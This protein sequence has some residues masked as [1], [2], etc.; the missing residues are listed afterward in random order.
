M[1][2]ILLMALALISLS[3]LPLPA[4]ADPQPAQEYAQNLRSE[5]ADSEFAADLVRACSSSTECGGGQNC[6]NTPSS[7]RCTSE[8]CGSLHGGSCVRGERCV[9]WSGKCCRVIGSGCI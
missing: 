2:R 8:Y 9:S 4:V 5:A 1:K 7:T 6:L 3:S